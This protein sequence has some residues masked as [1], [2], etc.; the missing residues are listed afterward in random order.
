MADTRKNPEDMSV[1]EI[2]AELSQDPGFMAFQVQIND[3]E[4][5]DVTQVDPMSLV[6][7]GDDA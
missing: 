6:E 5:V 4:V 7:K 1:E 2:L 3:G